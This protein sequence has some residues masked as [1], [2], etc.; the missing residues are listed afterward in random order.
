[1]QRPTITQCMARWQLV[2][3]DTHPFIKNKNKG[4]AGL[5]LEKIL[6]IPTSSACLDCQ[7]GEIKAFPVIKAGKRCRIQKEGLFYPKET[8][9]VTMCR[10]ELDLQVPFNESR[11]KKK[12]SSVL[13][14][15]Y[16]YLPNEEKIKWI[17]EKYFETTNPI[18]QQLEKDYLEIQNYYKE[19][20]ETK[21]RI[22]KLLQ[23]RTKGPGGDK[24]S[25]AFYLKKQ[26]MIQLFN[27]N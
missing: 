11:V 21:S 8:V 5:L 22:G 17:N 27:Q 7:D 18:F 4:K 1:M 2:K 26:F 13:F 14:I 9:A 16:Q 6:G 3:G 23:I 25:W 24:K 12:L 20:R 19:N 15:Q 10:P